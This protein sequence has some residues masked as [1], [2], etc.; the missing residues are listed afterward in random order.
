MGLWQ[1]QGIPGRQ[2]LIKVMH[3]SLS[4]SANNGH[5][6]GCNMKEVKEEK[7][8]DPVSRHVSLVIIKTCVSLF[9]FLYPSSPCTGQSH[10]HLKNESQDT[11][12]NLASAKLPGGTT[13]TFKP[14]WVSKIKHV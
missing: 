4:L 13:A 12:K 11:F 6:N 5:P 10:D 14:A 7:D 8:Y 1:I 2:E 3:P 9:L